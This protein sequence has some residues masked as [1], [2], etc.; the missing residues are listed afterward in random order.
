[1]ANRSKPDRRREDRATST[2]P[3]DER[4]ILHRLGRAGKRRRRG[5]RGGDAV[6]PAHGRSHRKDQGKSPRRRRFQCDDQPGLDVS[7]TVFVTFWVLIALVALG[8]RVHFLLSHPM[9]YDESYNY[10]EI[11]SKSP[12]H[13]ATHYLPN[14]HILHTLFVWASAAVFLCDVVFRVL[15]TEPA[16]WLYS[17]AQVAFL[18]ILYY[19]ILFFVGR[20]RSSGPYATARSIL[21]EL[22]LIKKRP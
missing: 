21:L 20:R 16:Y 22:S 7:P 13:A 6:A 9:R 5:D 1:M 8:V 12:F 11:A 17:L 14:N 4:L 18:G 15:R 3:R 19:V 10:L 2:E